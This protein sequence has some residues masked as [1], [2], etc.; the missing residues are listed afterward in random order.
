MDLK[1]FPDCATW[2]SSLHGKDGGIDSSGNKTED[3]SKASK[4]RSLKELQLAKTVVIIA[5]V[6]IVCSSP[7]AIN[8]LVA[9][10]LPQYRGTGTYGNTY[11]FVNFATFALSMVNSS[12]N[13]F[14]YLS[15]G[16]IFRRAVKRLF[17]LEG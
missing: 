17:R 5:I 14:I 2:R 13:F 11:R 1:C 4:S 9:S 8:V 12:A 3:R 15:T 7:N 10:A 6:F 16:T